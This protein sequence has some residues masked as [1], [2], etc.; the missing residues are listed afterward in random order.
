MDRSPITRKAI[1]ALTYATRLALA[2]LVMVGLVGAAIAQAQ[3]DRNLLAWRGASTEGSN[4][5]FLLPLDPPIV[6]VTY[7]AKVNDSLLGSATDTGFYLLRLGFD[8]LPLSVTDGVYTSTG[9]NGD[10]IHGTFSG[11]VRPSQKPGILVS[12]TVGFVTGGK[13]RFAGAT[14]H[15]LTRSEI[16][17]ATGKGGYSWEGVISLPKQ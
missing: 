4:T 12:E 13:G 15:D 5:S 3:T 7:T 16:E 6:V 8:G 9:A 10:A 17:L 14:G 11:L 2:V 1:N